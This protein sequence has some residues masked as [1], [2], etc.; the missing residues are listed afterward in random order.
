[1]FNIFQ[2]DSEKYQ[3]VWVSKNTTRAVNVQSIDTIKTV[4]VNTAP[5]LKSV[6]KQLEPLAK[7]KHIQLDLRLFSDSIYADTHKECF[8]LM[9]YNLIGH[10]LKDAPI[11]GCVTVDA[12][13]EGLD[14]VLTVMNN[15]IAFTKEEVSFLFNLGEDANNLE[16][17]LIPGMGL[18]SVKRIVDAHK[19]QLFAES[20]EGRGAAYTVRLHMIGDIYQ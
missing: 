3:S 11:H 9:A 14:F 18:D 12:H 4:R 6:V 17:N 10:S 2:T 13:T 19:G 15:G 20:R 16:Q 5:L 1:M 8:C 7:S